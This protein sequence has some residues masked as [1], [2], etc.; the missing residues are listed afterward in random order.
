MSK[1]AALWSAQQQQNLME[2]QR[3]SW[4][5]PFTCANRSDGKHPHE[6]EF[7]DHGVLRAGPQGWSCPY[8]SYTQDWAHDHMFAGAPPRPFTAGFRKNKP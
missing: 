2:W 7:G 6:A 5:H 4:I 1:P 8:C 3:S